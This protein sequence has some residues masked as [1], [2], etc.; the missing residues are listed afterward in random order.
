MNPRALLSKFFTRSSSAVRSAR[1]RQMGFTMAEVL[2]SI[3]VFTISV[4]GVVAMQRASIAAE[5]SASVLREGQRLASNQMEEMQSRSFNDLVEFDFVGQPNPVYPFDDLQLVRTFAYRDVPM[6]VDWNQIAPGQIPP[7]MR[8]DLYRVVRK[9]SA[10]PEGVLPGN[11]VDVQAIQIDVWV[12]W[13][14]YQPS[15]PIPDAVTVDQ[16]IPDM[17]DSSSVMFRDYVQGVHMST[18]RANDGKATEDSAP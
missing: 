11:P 12:L 3:I 7:G 17:L 15:S 6:D 16:L 2:L 4:V 18:V 1:R 13:L 14:D 9:I 8:R 5:N 10:L